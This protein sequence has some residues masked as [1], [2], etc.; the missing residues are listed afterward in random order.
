M[1]DPNKKKY[2]K[3]YLNHVICQL[4]FV[5]TEVISEEP[6]KLY[7]GSLGDDYAELATIRQRGVIIESSGSQLKSRTEDSN[8]WQIES[9]DKTHT[10]TITLKSFSITYR[11]YVK[12]RDYIEIV[13]KAQRLF[14]A[15]FDDI[16]I[17]NR[18]GLRYV[19]Q[20]KPPKLEKGWGQYID[21]SLT[22]SF[23]FVDS[24][25]LRRSMH[26][27][28]IQHDD[29]TKVNF[30]YGLFN[31]YFP[32]PIVDDEFILDIDAYTDSPQK[33][34]DCRNLIQNFNKIIA[35]YFE[36]SITDELRNEM[37]VIED[38]T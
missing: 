18:V 12:F 13:T 9:K 8:L 28:S 21:G 24:H 31:E 27:M 17:I 14:F 36:R 11:N 22:A 4:T 26:S 38:A 25:M 19:N 37:R 34:E 10:I 16:S 33:F 3:N 6:L 30:K 20:I 35:I 1:P 15:Q 2:K 5:K 23:D 29:D 7:K 32:A